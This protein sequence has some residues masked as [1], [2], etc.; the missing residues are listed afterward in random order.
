[1][2]ELPEVEH[3]RRILLRRQGRLVDI[4]V[5]DAAALRTRLSTRP[6][7]IDVAGGERLRPLLGART[8]AIV[9]HGKRL[10]W[11]FAGRES[12]LLVHLGMTGKWTLDVAEK[13]RVVLRFE[14]GPLSFV[15][16]RRFGSITVVPELVAMM[17]MRE[18]HGPDA[19]LETPDPATLRSLLRGTRA[20]KVAL[21]DQ[22]VIAGLG[23][24]HASEILWRIRVSPELP[25]NRITDAGATAL[26]EALPVHLG[27]FVQQASAE[28]EISYLNQGGPNPFRIYDREGEPC[29]RCGKPILATRQSGRSTYSCPSCQKA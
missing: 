3:C 6:S 2:P 5:R 18:G 14:D 22:S 17:A 12:V 27:E 13:A 21:M 26:S 23:N 29:P 1:M 25:C 24:I 19:L 28:D 20:V 10:G 15:D 7:E 4:E 9:R 8:E 11:W 16:S